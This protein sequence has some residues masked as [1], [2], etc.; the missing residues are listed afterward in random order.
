MRADKER[1]SE[2]EI[3]LP[4]SGLC[5]RGAWH[6]PMSWPSKGKK[7][8]QGIPAGG[9]FIRRAGSKKGIWHRRKGITKKREN[10][11]IRCA[12]SAPREAAKRK[13]ELAKGTSSVWTAKG[14]EW[15]DLDAIIFGDR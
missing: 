13:V 4:Q 9:K 6:T 7:D 10:K 11:P 1:V 3:T 5:A 12:R 2:A 15:G 8:C 14:G